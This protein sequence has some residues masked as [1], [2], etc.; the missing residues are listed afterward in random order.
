MQNKIILGRLGTVHGVQGWIKLHS[1]THPSSNILNHIQDWQIKDPQWTPLPIEKHKAHGDGY[2]IKIKGIDDREIAKRFTNKDIAIERD[3]LP[4]TQPN[5]YYWSDLEGLSVITQEGVTLGKIDHLMNSGANDIL[6][7]KGDRKRLLPFLK[8][9]I[10][11]VDMEAQQIIV[12][13]N[14]EDG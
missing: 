13:W 5:E 4:E 11:K 9:V 12:D 3:L 10:V 1:F 6:V 7:V 2:V 14:P 8:H